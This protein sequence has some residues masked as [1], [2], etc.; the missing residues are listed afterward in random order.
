MR[1]CVTTYQ[2]HGMLPWSL[3]EKEPFNL[4]FNDTLILLQI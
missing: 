4:L 2:V 1:G 3:P